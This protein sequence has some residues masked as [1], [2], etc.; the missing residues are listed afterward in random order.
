VGSRGAICRVVFW[1]R[2][3]ADG[4]TKQECLDLIKLLSA[5]ESA[6]LMTKQVMPDHLYDQISDVMK[7]LTREVLK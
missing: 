1:I 3:W 5:I 2:D 6:L 4:M 7:V